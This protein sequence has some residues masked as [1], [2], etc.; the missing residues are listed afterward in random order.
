MHRECGLHLVR[1]VG[2][3]LLDVVVL[4]PMTASAQNATAPAVLAAQQTSAL[5]QAENTGQDYLR[6]LNMFQLR[7]E[8][9]TAPGS[10]KEKGTIRTVTSDIVALRADRSRPSMGGWPAHRSAVSCEEPDQ[11]RQTGSSHSIQARISGRT[12]AIR[13]LVRLGG[14]FCHSTLCSAAN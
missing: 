9:E 3:W 13:S 7:Y 12:T 14:C 11:F 10:G 6:P 4:Q 8:Y 1:L 5:G 2:S